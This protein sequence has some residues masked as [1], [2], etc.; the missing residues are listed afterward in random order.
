MNRS[1]FNSKLC[2]IL[3]DTSKFKWVNI[4]EGKALNYLIH[5]EE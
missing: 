3:E 5:M 1:D 4:E 2:K